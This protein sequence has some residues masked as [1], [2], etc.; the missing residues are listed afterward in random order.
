MYDFVAFSNS[1]NPYS[2]STI[3]I[4]NISLR[5]QHWLCDDDPFPCTTVESSTHLIPIKLRSLP[6]VVYVA[7]SIPQ[8]YNN[9]VFFYPD[10]DKRE[11]MYSH[12]KAIIIIF[13]P[14]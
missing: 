5:E 7:H 10:L 13:T 4:L 9:L 11:P 2:Y 8:V 12:L 1:A 3:P 14:K 6:I